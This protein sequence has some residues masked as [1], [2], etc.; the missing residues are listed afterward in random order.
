MSNR[1][2]IAPAIQVGDTVAFTDGYIDRHSQYPNDLKSAQGQV[3]TLH[4]LKSGI[5]L[6]DIDWN[7][8]GFPKR[9]SLKNLTKVGTASFAQ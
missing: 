5:I 6:A 7:K 3:K 1:H 8:P 9:V 4:R 2:T